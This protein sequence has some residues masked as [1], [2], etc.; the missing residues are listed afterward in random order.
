[1]ICIALYLILVIIKIVNTNKNVRSPNTVMQFNELK[2]NLPTSPT[3][4]SS[5]NTTNKI[6]Q[7]LPVPNDF[8]IYW[9]DV[10]SYGNYPSG[11]VLTDKGFVIKASKKTIKNNSSLDDEERR[12][13]LKSGLYR[14]I[15]WDHLN[16]EDYDLS[17]NGND[18]YSIYIGEEK[19]TDFGN[20][21]LYDSLKNAKQNYE[22]RYLI[23]STTSTD[24]NIINPEAV[25][26]NATY[27][28][29]NSQTGHGI[30]AEEVGAKVDALFGERSTVVGRDN[31]KNG[32]DKI[33]TPYNSKTGIPVQCKYHKSAA[34]SIQSCFKKNVT[35]GK[36]EFRYFQLDGK[37][38]MLIEVPSD[39]YETAIIRM[40]NRIRKGQVPGITDPNMA[41]DIIR[42]G[43]ITYQQAKNLARAGSIESLSYDVTNGAIHCAY[44]A[45]IS[46]IAVFAITYWQ[47]KDKEK[48]SIAAFRT[49]LQV[50]MP[51]LAGTILS[52]QIARTSIPNVLTPLTETFSKQLSPQMVQGILNSF[53][54][55]IGKKK[56]YGAAAQKCFAKVL[57]TTV[58]TDI[59]IFGISSIPDTYKVITGKITKA[60]YTKN[61]LSAAAALAGAAGGAFAVKKI[62]GDNNDNNLIAKAII[63]CAGM[64]TGALCGLLASKALSA[65]KEDDVIINTRMFNAIVSCICVDYLLSKEEIN[66]LILLL[67]NDEQNVANCIV[68]LTGS[69]KQ[70]E[71][72]SNFITPYIVTVTQS[73][74]LCIS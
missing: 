56:V 19:V 13:L 49:G 69:N 25:A 20:K 27:G 23:N 41:K 33:V 43:R 71:T 8:K 29:D 15:P 2:D 58:I 48:A 73:R 65:I 10:Y 64:A 74:E 50:F 34:G 51:T 9:A 55:L 66:K 3:N 38:P 46:A 70:F 52:S 60:Q 67:D 35:T 57:R 6:K 53:R 72:V 61:I 12:R 4:I 37:T 26:F 32:P 11:I 45:G 42:K 47:T 22:K 1:V 63:Y 31:A 5:T 54:P 17:F 18:L 24:I 68:N 40:Q 36:M 14:I 16:Y 28:E 7:Y 39:Q 44:A 30:Y 62:L 21:G 59:V